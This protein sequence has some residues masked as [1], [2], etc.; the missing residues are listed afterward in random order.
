MKLGRLILTYREDLIEPMRRFY[1]GEGRTKFLV[2]ACN[3]KFVSPG[4][5]KEL[6][7]FKLV[8]YEGA[9][10]GGNVPGFQHRVWLDVVKRFPETEAWVIHDYDLVARPSDQDVFGRIKEGEYAMIG[11]PF[12]VWQKGMSEVKDVDTYPFPQ[13]HKHW[14]VPRKGGKASKI[15]H[16]GKLFVLSRDLDPTYWT[17]LEEFPVWFGGVK[18]FLGGY[19]DFL[20]THRKNLL[21]LDDVRLLAPGVGGHEQV[22]HTVFALN[23]V[24]PVDMRDFYKTKIKMD[25]QYLPPEVFA[26]SGYDFLHPVKFWP[27]VGV[28]PTF[29]DKLHNE[30]TALKN[31]LKRA[32]K[33]EGWHY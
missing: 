28:Q 18:T 6:E 33:Y 14:C 25:G 5:F 9:G 31:F 3:K 17:L 4:V 15:F 16:T 12:P 29:G 20:A 27:S 32:I 23:N 13:G 11:R 21:L 26:N 1:L 2:I 24:K 8:P 30:I 19:S 10:P 7:N 22:P